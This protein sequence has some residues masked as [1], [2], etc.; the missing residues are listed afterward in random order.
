M[1]PRVLS[2][3]PFVEAVIDR[4]RAEFDAVVSQDR[5]L[6]V[7]EILAAIEAVP[8]E[9]LL[10]SSRVKYD[11][12]TIEAL[13]ARVKVMATVSVGYDHIDVA[14]ATKRGLI[15]TNTPDV[16]TDAT[17]DMTF[18]LMLGA[19]RRAKEYGQIMQAGW[20][21]RH[22][23]NE[24]LGIDVSGK[25]LGILG[26]GRIG[27][28][29]AQRARGFGMKILY[30]NT[31]RLPPE[32]EGDATYCASFE[33]MLSRSQ[34]LTLHT[35]GGAGTDNIINQRTLALLPRGAVLINAARGK[36]VDEDALIAALQS[37]RLAAAG[38]DV[39][40]TEPDYDLRLR[41]LPNAFL[42]PHMGSST[43]ETRTAMGMRALDN[44]A[45]ALRGDRPSDW[46][47]APER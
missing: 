17:A 45:A 14:A 36:L 47:N 19:C 10:V 28:A 25:T 9:G 37:G 42:T 46:V 8:A 43:L 35:P 40:R 15:V 11:A 2:V 38:L 4:A 31:K 12:A 34:I 5:T 41:D 1:A 33:E 44:I 24:M 20:R 18:L 32:L 27:R 16:L 23:P 6:T 21:H 7:P 30:H 29:V 26:M 39:F 3:A 13:P 22:E